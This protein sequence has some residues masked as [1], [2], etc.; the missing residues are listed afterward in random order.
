MKRETDC[1]FQTSTTPLQK[2]RRFTDFRTLHLL[3][4]TTRTS[5]YVRFPAFRPLNSRADSNAAAFTFQGSME[6]GW[7]AKW[8]HKKSYSSGPHV[9]QLDEIKGLFD[10]KVIYI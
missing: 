5:N 3:L 10:R 9:V 1:L 2:G 6:A 7:G 4:V 8:S